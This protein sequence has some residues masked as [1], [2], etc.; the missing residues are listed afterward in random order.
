MNALERY[1]ELENIPKSEFRDRILETYAR[2]GIGFKFASGLLKE[3]V[4]PTEA[5]KEEFDSEDLGDVNDKGF[6]GE[7]Q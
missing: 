3:Y 7:S 6:D 5:Y 4:N 1:V 2:G